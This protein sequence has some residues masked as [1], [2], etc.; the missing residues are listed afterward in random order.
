[1]LHV[2]RGHYSQYSSYIGSLQ[3]TMIQHFF[4]IFSNGIIKSPEV[5]DAM[6]HVDRGHYSPNGNSI[7]FI[8][9]IQLTMIQQISFYLQQWD[10]QVLLGEGCHAAG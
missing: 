3:L 2:D 5:R 8:D 10:Y 4:F 1:M 7:F 9:S 6:L